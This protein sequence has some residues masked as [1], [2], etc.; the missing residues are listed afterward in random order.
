MPHPFPSYL[1]K[2]NLYA[3]LL[4][5]NTLILHPLIF[6]T[7]TLP[8]LYRTEY[9]PTEK[10]ISLRFECPVIYGLRFFYLAK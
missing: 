10:P 1:C 7:D 6:S 5:D 2:C 4:A 8:V 3:A 9:L